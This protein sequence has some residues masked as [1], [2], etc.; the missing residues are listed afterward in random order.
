MSKSFRVRKKERCVFEDIVCAF[1]HALSAEVCAI[2]RLY[3]ED[4]VC[5]FVYAG[6]CVSRPWFGSLHVN[7]V[8][9]ISYVCAHMCVC[10]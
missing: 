5:G 9:R 8:T 4:T 2:K 3:G 1:A 7:R 10:K 6:A